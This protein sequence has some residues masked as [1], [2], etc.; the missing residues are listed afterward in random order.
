MSDT[1][2]GCG[3]HG[4]RIAEPVGQ[5]VNGG[6]CCDEREIR[7]ALSRYRKLAGE[8]LAEVARLEGELLRVTEER[9]D[10]RTR[11]TKASAETREVREHVAQ[12][13]AMLPDD[14]RV[15]WS[16]KEGGASPDGYVVAAKQTVR[17]EDGNLWCEE[18]ADSFEPDEDA[19]APAAGSEAT[20]SYPLSVLDEGEAPEV[21]RYGD[22]E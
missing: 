3:T 6:C 1:L 14:L 15:C 16:C 12:L 22:E 21:G 10:F 9:E 18:C 2:Q 7:R 19:T 8:R 4:C 5:G 11:W 20:V 17:D 13:E